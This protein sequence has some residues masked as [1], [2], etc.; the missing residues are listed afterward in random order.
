MRAKMYLFQ[1]P[2]FKN[3]IVQKLHTFLDLDMNCENCTTKEMDTK[4]NRVHLQQIS[5]QMDVPCAASAQLKWALRGRD[6]AGPL[7]YADT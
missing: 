5:I 3:K 6:D 2:L 4:T 7:T 1:V